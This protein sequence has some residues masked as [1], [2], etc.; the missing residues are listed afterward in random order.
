MSTQNENIEL[1]ILDKISHALVHQRNASS[2][3]REVLDILQ[4]EMGFEHGAFTLR[5][6]NI[7]VIEAST[8]LNED[9][10]KRGQYKMGEGVNGKVASTGKAVIIPDIS[11]DS[12]FLGKTKAKRAAKTAYVCVPIKHSGEVIG[13]LGIDHPAASDEKLQ[14]VLGLLK[15]LS[16]ILADAV[17][18]FKQEIEEKEQ[19][20][21]ENERLRQELGVQFHPSNII[22]NCS[23]M[24]AV[25]AMIAQVADSPA[26]VLIRGESGTGKELVARAIHYASP[27]KGG[28]FIAVNCAALP[29]NLIESELFG[30]EK[31][32]FTGAHQQRKGR[33]EIANG[34]TL[35]LDEIGDIS[36]A[37][38]VRL[39][40]VLQERVF[41]RVGGHELVES[42]ARIIAATSRDLEQ[43]IQENKFR[44]D[45]YYRLNVFPIILPAL[46]ERKSDIILLA[47]HFLDKYNRTYNKNV[48]RISTPAINMMMAYHWPGNVRE[49]ENSLER[50]VLVTTNDVV[51][52]YDLPPS[53]QTAQESGT[54]IITEEGASFETMV[55]SFEKELI[56]DALK[57]NRW[58]V[59]A[60]AR[61][62][63][64]TQRIMH[65][66]IEKLNIEIQK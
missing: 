26:T 39:L 12:S 27:R 60:A 46:R 29:E 59:A 15:I 45:L 44:E 55:A 25:Y 17:A 51:N 49:L 22:G 9:E 34:G 32:S 54:S 33:F 5:R 63:N 8:G 56:V 28:P 23:G 48:R 1:N 20:R 53:L 64:T 2:L 61:A 3:L 24:K 7:L 57:N 58:N 10:K 11:K 13:T 47:D 52:A 62:L 36:Q 50:A 18:T 16:N 37:V 42:N 14:K 35:F 38:Q 19:L 41:E 6:G 40:R 43:A 4:H 21:N 31:G 30:H 66:K 65:Y